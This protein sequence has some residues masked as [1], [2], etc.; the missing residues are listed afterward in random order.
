LLRSYAA[1]PPGSHG[2]TPAEIARPRGVVGSVL[3][4]RGP[5][6]SSFAK[7][8]TWISGVALI[9]LLIACANVANLLLARAL[10]R[11]REIAI[12]LALGVSRARLL[13]QL[14]TES[15]LL[16]LLGGLAGLLIAVWGRAVL[17]A[18]S[19]ARG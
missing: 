1:Q 11:R 2:L 10:R 9:V 18:E 13:S 7:V 17:G 6:E 8:A 5:N 4:E 14:F 19:L 16:A 15:V 12:R 3:S